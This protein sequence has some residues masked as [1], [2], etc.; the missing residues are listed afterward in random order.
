[1]GMLNFLSEFFL[2]LLAFLFRLILLLTQMNPTSAHKQLLRFWRE[3]Q[4]AVFPILDG[5]IFQIQ[6]LSEN[7]VPMLLGLVLT[8]AIDRECIVISFAD[9]TALT[10]SHHI[11]NMTGPIHLLSPVNC[12]EDLLSINSSIPENWRLET[13][14]TEIASAISSFTKV[15]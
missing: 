14:I 9:F 7:T 2:T 12:R 3:T 6:Q 13:S 4:T 1:M 10:S 11:D 8:N 15:I 5:Y